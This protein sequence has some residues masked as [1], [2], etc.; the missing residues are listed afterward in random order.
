[1]LVAADVCEPLKAHGVT[2]SSAETAIGMRGAIQAHRP[3]VGS[4]IRASGDPRAAIPLPPGSS[5]SSSCRCARPR[6][7]AKR[8]LWEH[9]LCEPDRFDT[10]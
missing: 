2:T 10:S 7:G 3:D 5:P 6:K 1:V 4:N 8:E 9:R